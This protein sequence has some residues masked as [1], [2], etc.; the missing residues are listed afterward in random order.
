MNVPETEQDLI[1]EFQRRQREF[2]PR[3]NRNIGILFFPGF[4]LFLIGGQADRLWLVIPGIG[5][6]LAGAVRGL[7]LV[8]RY[9]RCPECGALQMPKMHAPY[10]TC[11]GCGSRLSTGFKDSM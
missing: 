8:L 10:R 3:W 6:C 7:L 4:V 9:R 5:L 1:A 2:K 11:E